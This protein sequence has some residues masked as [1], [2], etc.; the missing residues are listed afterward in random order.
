[1]DT[2]Q[3]YLLGDPLPSFK[4]NHLPTKMCVLRNIFHF[5]SD[6]KNTYAE[7]VNLTTDLLM[8]FYD[9]QGIP[10]ITKTAVKPKVLRLLSSYKAVCQIKGRKRPSP[11]LKKKETEFKQLLREVFPIEKANGE[12]RAPR[13]KMAAKNENLSDNSGE[14]SSDEKNDEP[15]DNDDANVAPNADIQS[16]PKKRVPARKQK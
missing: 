3:K 13:K 9:K 10:T 12:R 15:S 4:P 5:Q 1:M 7:S 6:K 14:G 8:D 11:N 2:R 16:P